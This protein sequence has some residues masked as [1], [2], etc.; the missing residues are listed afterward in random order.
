MN[1]KSEIKIGV[2]VP[3]GS[4]VHER[5]FK[6]LHNEGVQFRFLGFAYPMNSS[7]FCTDF[8]KAM[9]PPIEE[10]KAWGAELVLIGCTTATMVCNAESWRTDLEKIA[11]VPIVTAASASRDA[12]AAFGAKSLAIASPYG[13]RANA[14]VATFI[15]SLGVEIAVLKGQNI[16]RTLDN[17]FAQA[18]RMTGQDALEFSLTVDV[19]EAQAMYLPCTGVDTLEA[20]EP[21]EQ[22]TGKPAFSSVQA[23]Y[24][25]SLRRLGFDGRQQ[26]YGRLLEVW[27]F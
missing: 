20:I 9:L 3:A 24:W 10:F 23:G 1:Q 11:G 15:K 27:D 21:F 2:V 6:R 13:D 25:A 18:P 26:G 14:T 19:P 16:D 4:I 22:R 8:A 5:E 12:I 7:D 17:W